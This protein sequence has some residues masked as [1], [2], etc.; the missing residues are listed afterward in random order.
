MMFICLKI[1]LQISYLYLCLF[2]DEVETQ[3]FTYGDEEDAYFI[4]SVLC[5]N[6]SFF[7]ETD[8]IDGEGYIL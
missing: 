7:I 2:V 6:P 3:N 1:Y 8:L 5:I 4:D